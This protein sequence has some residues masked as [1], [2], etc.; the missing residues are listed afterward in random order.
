MDPE[1]LALLDIHVH[2]QLVI[3]SYH[4]F[5]YLMSIQILHDFQISLHVHIQNYMYILAQLVMMNTMQWIISQ[6]GKNCDLPIVT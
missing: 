4:P 2:H 5:C 3:K 6:H 1:F